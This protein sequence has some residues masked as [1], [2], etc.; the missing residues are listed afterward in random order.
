MEP[1]RLFSLCGNWPATAKTV[2]AAEGG[3]GNQIHAH[4]TI[5]RMILTI[6]FLSATTLLG[7]IVTKCLLWK[8]APGNT[9][10]QIGAGF[11][12]GA[13]ITGLFAAHSGFSVRITGICAITVAAAWLIQALRREHSKYIAWVK[14]LPAKALFYKIGSLSTRPLATSALVA[15]LIITHWVVAL[16]NN[17]ARPI[18]PWDAFTTW[19]YRAKA[20]TLT[21]TITPMQPAIDWLQRGGG[22]DFAIY[23]SDYS[24]TLSAFAAMCS[25]VSGG[26]HEGAAS[27]PWSSAFLA[28]GLIVY[29][30]LRR[31]SLPPL[32]SIVGAYLLLSLPLLET[33]AAL[34]GYADLWMLA[35][36][37]IGL[38][39]L[40]LWHHKPEQ[41]IFLLAFLLLLL[42]SQLKTEGWMWLLLGSI[43]TLLSTTSQRIGYRWPLLIGLSIAG[44]IV[45]TQTYH[46]D[47]G[48]LGEWG[49]A[50]QQL[51]A[52]PFGSFTLRPFNALPV[53]AKLVFYDASFHLL[54]VLS[55]FGLMV[56]TAFTPRTARHWWVMVALIAASQVVIF[57]LAQHSLYAEQGT[58]IGRLL[59]QV[60]PVFLVVGWV[61]LNTR[62][63]PVRPLST[64]EASMLGGYKRS[65]ANSHC[66]KPDSTN[67]LWLTSGL[68]LVGLLLALIVTA[69]QFDSAPASTLG[70][71]GAQSDNNFSHFFSQW[72]NSVAISHTSINWLA[73]ATGGIISEISFFSIIVAGAML[74]A[75]TVSLF[76]LNQRKRLIKSV[77]LVLGI[78]WLSSD[79]IWLNRSL[80]N[81]I[82]L[83]ADAQ[84]SPQFREPN[85]YYLNAI[86]DQITPLIDDDRPIYVAPLDERALFDA[87]KLT[88]LLLPARAAMLNP[89]Q[90]DLP[91]D[92]DG[93]AVVI[94]IDGKGLNYVASQLASNF[95]MKVTAIGANFR[96]LDSQN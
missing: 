71:A 75:L 35:T 54:A 24:A 39:M 87:S 90:L 30:M 80:Q 91:I 70:I 13:A 69:A 9:Q 95:N 20:W 86:A 79:I 21:D 43:F 89:A 57:G 2:L 25:A 8:R 63:T 50:G 34:A 29:G 17:L 93:Y 55:A 4:R 77:I 18:F 49:L 32:N 51:H 45:A 36:S 11:F 42:G 10:I 66:H 37:G 12:I 33:H 3:D 47:L 65:T 27:L 96:L 7:T 64:G 73:S 52:G 28:L 67:S 68:L 46:V 22:S 1:I 19:M 62:A 72:R 83:I 60:S 59:L 92:W 14:P 56:A 41:G 40:L 53:Y 84:A 15:T 94:S 74:S 78:G 5:L 6:L 16:V 23:A 44:F 58:A 31:W 82:Q 88:Y 81:T 85:G 26:W 38:S 48:V 76:A 61:G